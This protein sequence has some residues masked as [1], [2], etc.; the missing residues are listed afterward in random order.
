M[1]AG[2]LFTICGR[3]FSV[4]P[5][6]KYIY[7]FDVLAIQCKSVQICYTSVYLNH[8]DWFNERVLRERVRLLS[9][10]ATPQHWRIESRGNCNPQKR[11][12][13]HP[14]P[15][16]N[17]VHLALFARSTAEAGKHCSGGTGLWE[18]GGCPANLHIPTKIPFLFF[19]LE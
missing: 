19:S 7:F 5:Y 11:F 6:L 18:L 2:A 13:R 3:K 9:P 17:Q 12:D 8:D 1:H 16:A 14:I 15:V 10:A 4:E